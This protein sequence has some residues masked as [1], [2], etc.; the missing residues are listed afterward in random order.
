MSTITEY[1]GGDGIESTEVT[2]G[3]MGKPRPGDL[4][5]WPDGSYGRVWTVETGFAEQGQ[6]HVCRELGSAFLGRT[7]SR[8]AGPPPTGRG[9]YVS[10]SGGPF[11]IL[12]LD[13]L[14]PAV[15]LDTARFWNWGDNTPGAGRGV[16]YWL[17]RPVF[18][19]NHQP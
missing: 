1:V 6:V 17:P 10:I 4:I 11:L 8:T 7:G 5:E 14:E 9:V 13:E 3:R 16:D 15:R 2:R 12:E 18:K 19:T